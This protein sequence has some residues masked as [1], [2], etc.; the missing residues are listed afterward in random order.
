MV[1]ID[2]HSFFVVANEGLRGFVSVACPQFVSHVPSCFN[3]ARDC[4]KLYHCGKDALKTTLKG[5]KSRIT[6]TTDC[7]TSV[8][9]LNYLCLT[10]H[11][12][13]DEWTLYKRISNF[14]LMDSHKGK[15][16]GKFIEI[17]VIDW[18]IEDKLS[19]LT[20]SNASSNNVAV[21]YLKNNLGDKLVL[22]GDFFHMRCA[23]HV[24]NLVVEMVY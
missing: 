15:E 2:E 8:Q 20:I 22:D 1:V 5:L 13:D 4:K 7:W 14:K 18:G 11:F 12:I 3:V 10:I 16:I 17:C 23:P 24:L 6:L 21:G 9:N 19:C